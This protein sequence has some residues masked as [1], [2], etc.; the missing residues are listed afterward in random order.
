ARAGRTSRLALAATAV[1]DGA[2]ECA[3]PG[4]HPPGR[5]EVSRDR[6]RDLPA[7]RRGD[8]ARRTRG[9]PPD[10]GGLELA[11][12]ARDRPPRTAPSGRITR[13]RT[14]GRELPTCVHA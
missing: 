3:A 6:G 14:R 8:D 2:Q 11:W 1:R 4:S 7:A 12:L 13:N 10:R 9:P 5:L